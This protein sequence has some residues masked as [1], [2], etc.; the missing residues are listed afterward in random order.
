MKVHRKRFV[1]SKLMLPIVL[2]ETSD[3]LYTRTARLYD[4]GV[5]VLSLCGKPGLDGHCRIFK[6][7]GS[8]RCLLERDIY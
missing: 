6:V 2:Q 1:P 3:K 7:S 8:W 4:L 5:K